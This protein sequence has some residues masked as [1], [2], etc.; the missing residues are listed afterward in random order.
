MANR[1]GR[2]A[3]MYAIADGHLDIAR[4]LVKSGANT[5]ARDK[6]GATALMQA[7]AKGYWEIVRLLEQ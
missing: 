7:Q 2:T 3:L 4:L 5:D 1:Y 6:Y